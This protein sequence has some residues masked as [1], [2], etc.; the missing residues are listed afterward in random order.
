MGKTSKCSI[1]IHSI[2]YLS[3]KFL[4]NL[5]ANEDLLKLNKCSTE[6]IQDNEFCVILNSETLQ[7]FRIL[8][9]ITT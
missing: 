1:E 7:D 5:N 2:I 4:L 6:N 9:K 3:Y 8:Q